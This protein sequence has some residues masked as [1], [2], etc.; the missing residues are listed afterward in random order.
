M[1][2]VYDHRCVFYVNESCTI[3]TF[4]VENLMLFTALVHVAIA[5]HR[6]AALYRRCAV[7][8]EHTISSFV[9]I[10]AVVIVVVHNIDRS[11]STVSTERS[12]HS[13]PAGSTGVSVGGISVRNTN[14]Y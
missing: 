13:W 12:K 14:Q 1:F 3:C 2:A 10:V 7:V 6:R 11:A 5:V 4:Y 8:H 9:A